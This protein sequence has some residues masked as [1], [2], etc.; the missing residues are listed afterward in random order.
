MRHLLA[1]AAVLVLAGACLAAEFKSDEAKKAQAD[2]LA[3]LEAA[4]NIYGQ[5]LAKAKA[6]IDAKAAAATD[7]ISKEAI[8][9]ESAAITEELVRLRDADAA[10]FEPKEWKSAETKKAAAG[11]AAELKA[12][13]MKY[14]QDLARARQ[15]VLARKAAATDSAAKEAL[16][17]EIAL[18]EEEQASLKDES[19][20][21]KKP[22]KQGAWIDLLP[23]VDLKRDVVEG[24]WEATKSGLAVVGTAE[25]WPR[26]E[27]PLVPSGNY[28]LE[29]KFVRVSGSNIFV[30]LPVGSRSIALVMG[31]GG[32]GMNSTSGLQM[33]NGKF[34]LNNETRVR[35]ANIENGQ[36]YTVSIRV[37]ADEV[38]AEITIYLDGKPYTKWAGPLKV[39]SQHK[40]RELRNPSYLGL[41]VVDTQAVFQGVRLRMLTGSALPKASLEAGKGA[42]P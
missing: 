37:I 23:L 35:P 18:I 11:Y 17:A 38:N 28:E 41:G 16:Q 8:Q 34:I 12:A 24:K 33:I 31:L 1:L 27:M 36:P 6:T 29:V 21:A 7:A 15:A 2:Y 14:G 3:A 20:I 26:L 13:Q 25:P 9:S 40:V 32:S 5:G 39:L 4:K 10:A 42:K 19:K 30:V 22:V